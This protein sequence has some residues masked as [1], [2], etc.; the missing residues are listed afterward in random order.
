MDNGDDKTGEVEFS[1]CY[2]HTCTKT[3]LFTRQLGAVIILRTCFNCNCICFTGGV[4][5]VSYASTRENQGPSRNQGHKPSIV[6]RCSLRMM[7]QS[8]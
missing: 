5:H 7:T 6:F 3:T 4:E 1:L 8:S 2:L